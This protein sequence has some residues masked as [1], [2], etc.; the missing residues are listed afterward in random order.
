[1]LFFTI[2]PS[3]VLNILVDFCGLDYGVNQTTSTAFLRLLNGLAASVHSPLPGGAAVFDDM[4]AT[5]Q[6]WA[7]VFHCILRPYDAVDPVVRVTP[8]DPCD[9]LLPASVVERYSPS[10]ALWLFVN[11]A[12]LALL[13]QVQPVLRL[14]HSACKETM[15]GVVLSLLLERVNDDALDARRDRGSV[16]QIKRQVL[17]ARSAG[18]HLGNEDQGGLARITSDDLRR[19][20]PM[21]QVS[22]VNTRLDTLTISDFVSAMIENALPLR[23]ATAIVTPGSTISVNSPNEDKEN[24][25]AVGLYEGFD[26]SLDSERYEVPSYMLLVRCCGCCCLYLL[27]VCE[28]HLSTAESAKSAGSTAPTDPRS[29]SCT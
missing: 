26:D 23:S 22:S 8:R 21:V 11:T 10:D 27:F 1:M 25:S 14:L 19:V 20:W 3:Y 9:F 28:M 5:Y 24:T 4:R 2:H 6:L 13:R 29:C 7:R 16:L 17:I 18:W 15:R 12:D